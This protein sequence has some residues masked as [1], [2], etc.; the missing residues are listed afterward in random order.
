M[1][2][3]GAGVSTED[4]N[5]APIRIVPDSLHLL[6]HAHTHSLCPLPPLTCQT[7]YTVEFGVVREEGGAVKAFG[8]GILSSYGELERL[9]LA[10]TTTP[11]PTPAPREGEGE[12]EGEGL[13]FELEPFDPYAPQP[14]MSYKDGFQKRY[15][16]LDEGFEAGARRL[17]E[18]ARAPRV[19]E[20]GGGGGGGAPRA[21]R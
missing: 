10:S 18:F 3:G 13:P 12:G 15:F 20:A 21:A 8:A 5:R 7:G 4:E 16:V 1:W 9:L 17:V 14:K 2:R 11:A 6:L 19:P